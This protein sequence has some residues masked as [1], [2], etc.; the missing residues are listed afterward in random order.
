MFDVK[1]PGKRN[2]TIS[3]VTKGTKI[4]FVKLVCMVLSDV[5]GIL[6]C[7]TCHQTKTLLISSVQFSCILLNIKIWK[8][9]ILPKILYIHY[10]AKGI[11]TPGYHNHM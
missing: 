2:E 6:L 9:N 5:V 4:L 7:S 11:W 1:I 8:Q 10:M 3:K